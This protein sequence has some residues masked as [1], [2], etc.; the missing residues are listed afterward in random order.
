M[1]P[2]CL[3]L[4]SKDGAAAG[5]KAQTR[6]QRSAGMLKGEPC[7]PAHQPPDHLPSALQAYVTNDDDPQCASNPRNS[8]IS[9][10]LQASRT[11]YIL[12]DGYS[13]SW[14]SAQGQYRLTVAERGG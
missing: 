2:G 13:G 11:Y 9:T 6:L 10:R 1:F 4:Q 5:R 14:I 7:F 3:K 8:R 12:V